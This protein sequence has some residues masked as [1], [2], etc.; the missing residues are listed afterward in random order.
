MIGSDLNG[1]KW[2]STLSTTEPNTYRN[3]STDTTYNDHQSA[4]SGAYPG[5]Y[6]PA[7][8]GPATYE[9]KEFLASTYYKDCRWLM[10]AA[11][12]ALAAPRPRGADG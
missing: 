1:L 10:A 6:P 5:S 4:P 11:N 2:K 9:N 12:R 7:D 3:C 8:N